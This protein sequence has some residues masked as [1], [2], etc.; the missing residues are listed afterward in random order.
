MNA[1]KQVKATRSSWWV[2]GVLGFILGLIFGKDDPVGGILAGLIN[3]V[4]FGWLIGL[5]I[6]RTKYKQ[7]IPNNPEKW[8]PNRSHGMFEENRIIKDNINQKIMENSFSK[9]NDFK[10]QKELE[11]NDLLNE[12]Y[13]TIYH[14][15]SIMQNEFKK[16]EFLNEM[17][18]IISNFY[19][20]DNI[21]PQKL[22]DN[23]IT[24]NI[25]LEYGSLNWY[26][27]V[28]K[29]SIEKGISPNPTK[30]FKEFF[31]T[32]VFDRPL[33]FPDWFILGYPDVAMWI[34]NNLQ[35]IQEKFKNLE[36]FEG[37]D[38]KAIPDFFRQ[39]IDLYRENYQ[40][41]CKE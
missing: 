19:K 26:N 8:V 9:N 11:L 36:D 41:E 1:I 25:M 22:I 10:T 17:Q 40:L 16:N 31:C 3:G 15:E 14:Y 32:D 28:Q 2:G 23:L 18:K 29:T 27:Q 30:S 6:D 12:I 35:I 24:N 4:F 7:I 33:G 13:K 39:A 20:K 38:G 37:T 5:I 21:S 34:S